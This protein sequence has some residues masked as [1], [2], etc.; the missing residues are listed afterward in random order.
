MRVYYI[1]R[2]PATDPRLAGVQLRFGFAVDVP[3]P[4]GVQLIAEDIY[5]DRAD[6]AAIPIDWYKPEPG[7]ELLHL[8]GVGEGRAAMLVEHGITDLEGLLGLTEAEIVQLA[9]QLSGVT[10]ARLRG[11]IE[12]ARTTLEVY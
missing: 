2:E 7:E 3:D 12:E 11:W 5:T 1:G 4:L 6:E 10:E 8:D 9:A